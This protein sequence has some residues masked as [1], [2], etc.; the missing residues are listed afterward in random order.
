MKVFDALKARSSDRA[1]GYLNLE[2]ELM[3]AFDQ[4]K[5]KRTRLAKLAVVGV[6]CLLVT[7]AAAEAATGFLRSIIKSVTLDTGNGPQ[8]VTEYQTTEN[9]DG[10]VNVTVALPEGQTSGTVTVDASNE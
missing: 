7:G 4:Q 5:A 2:D 3:S 9:P 8:P 1:N 6:V 10:S